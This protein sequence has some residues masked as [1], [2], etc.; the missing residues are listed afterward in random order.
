MLVTSRRRTGSRSA[1]ALLA[2]AVGL[3]LASASAPAARAEGPAEPTCADVLVLGARPPGDPVTGSG[4][5]VGTVV[6]TVVADLAAAGRTVA[7]EDLAWPAVPVGVILGPG[8]VDPEGLD[9]YAG[10]VAAG[11]QAALVSLGTHLGACPAQRLVLVGYSQGALVWHLALDRL[12]D[13]A[14]A[15]LAAVSA[16]VLTADPAQVPGTATVRRGSAGPT[17]IGLAELARRLGLAPAGLTGDGSDVPDA[18]SDRTLSRC[19]AGDVVCDASPAVLTD[20]VALAAGARVH[21]L[22]G[23]AGVAGLQEDGSWAAAL[24]EADLARTPPTLA[25]LQALYDALRADGEITGPVAYLVSQDLRTAQR[26]VDRGFDEQAARQVQRLVRHVT[27]PPPASTV[28]VAARQD[29]L[30][31]A[32]GLLGAWSATTA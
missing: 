24:A 28:T 19:E 29:L 25:D 3:A 14:P 10:S 22:Y 16:T 6:G 32:A 23:L 30:A 4:A 21:A 20:P 9:A 18:V 17:A 27:S 2:A 8:G 26:L 11:T 12:A 15:A 31:L 13:D 5:V 1:A 7:T